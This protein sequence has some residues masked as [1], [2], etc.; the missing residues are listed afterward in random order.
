M[1]Y[2]ASPFHLLQFNVFCK[3][4][5]IQNDI[6]KNI[7]KRHNRTDEK[8]FMTN[9]DWMR[10]GHF[11]LIIFFSFNFLLLVSQFNLAFVFF[12]FFILLFVDL[13]TDTH[14]HTHTKNTLTILMHT[15]N[16]PTWNRQM[17]FFISP[18]RPHIHTQ[19]KTWQ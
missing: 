15:F 5:T 7:N 18:T 11:H 4:K 6:K 9:I 3:W 1:F 2:T 12:F 19:K 16:H 17:I 10:N 8:C 14:T 13:H